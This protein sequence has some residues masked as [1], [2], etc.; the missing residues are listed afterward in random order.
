MIR[1]DD[2]HHV[3][4]NGRIHGL[5]RPD[6]G[7]GG[8]GA[9]RD[10]SP[11][12]EGRPDATGDRQVTGGGS[13]TAGGMDFQHS[14]SAWL[15]VLMLAEK[16][17]VM[18]QWLP[19][20]TTLDWLR[21]ETEQPIDDIMA[22]TSAG[23]LIFIQA[24]KALYL[25]A[26]EGSALASVVDQCVRQIISMRNKPTGSR[27]W[28]RGPDPARDRFVIVTSPDSSKAVVSHAGN[29]LAR[30]RSLVP[31]MALTDAAKN[32]DERKVLDALT[33]HTNASWQR[34]TGAAPSEAELANS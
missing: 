1:D 3:I 8:W 22:G 17:A 7:S 34:A 20:G 31:G 10:A 13:A 33:A 28:D 23:G 24:K 15:A 18:P 4:Q 9:L 25:S 2:Q 11:C 6:F 19:A 21:C 27:P 26:G 5:C 14:V 12:R 32:D 30:L 29:M 16:D